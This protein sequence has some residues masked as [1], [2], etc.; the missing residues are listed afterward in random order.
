MMTQDRL[1]DLINRGLGQAAL[2]TGALYDVFRPEG[3]ALPL[4]PARRMI[5]LSC[6]L[7][8]GAPNF[9]RQPM[10]GRPHWYA[11]MDAAYVQ[12]GDYLS[13]PLGVFFVASLAALAPPM[14]M[15]CDRVLD[16]LRAEEV[17]ASGLE[18]YGGETRYTLQPVLRGWP[19]SVLAGAPSARGELPAEGRGATWHV[20]LPVLPIP[21]RAADLLVDAAGVRFVVVSAE[22]SAEGWRLLAQQAEV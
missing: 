4:D 2:R 1:Q 8:A 15:R 3:P 13:G 18:E 9:L 5:Q 12:V 6:T 19:A 17:P 22:S 16:V 21:L 7:S 11:V 10:P 20:L 14:V